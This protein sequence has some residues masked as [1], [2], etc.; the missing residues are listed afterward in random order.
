ME[1]DKL[2]MEL[3]NL[4]HVSDD[5]AQKQ[6]LAYKQTLTDLEIQVCNYPLSFDVIM[7]DFCVRSSF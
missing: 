6:Q 5:N 1:R 2:M 3:E 7:K 4:S